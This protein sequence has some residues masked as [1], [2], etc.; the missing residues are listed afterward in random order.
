MNDSFSV[1]CVPTILN[2]AIV[3]YSMLS[4][5]KIFG[6]D[7]H[8]NDLNQNFMEEFQSISFIHQEST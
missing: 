3:Q 7:F 4:C 8:K 1:V 5:F 2:C 6:T